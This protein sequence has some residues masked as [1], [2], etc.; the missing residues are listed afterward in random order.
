MMYILF[1]LNNYGN[2]IVQPQ[3]ASRKTR[4]SKENIWETMNIDIVQD[5]EYYLKTIFNENSK[6]NFITLCMKLIS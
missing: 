6:E 2:V 1:K 3:H 4:K 5:S